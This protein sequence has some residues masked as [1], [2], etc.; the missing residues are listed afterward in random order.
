MNDQ[1]NNQ[2]NAQAQE[3]TNQPETL[4]YKSLKASIFHNQGQHGDF[5]TTKFARSYKDQ[6][7]NYQD[8]DNFRAKD[9]LGL[10]ELSRR[11]DSR[12]NELEREAYIKQ[13]QRAF[14]QGRGNGRSQGHE[15]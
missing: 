1:N 5:F 9:L 10:S 12:V 11:A 4:R 15:Q 13:K 14:D 2:Q 7:G 6:E 8:T 3:Q